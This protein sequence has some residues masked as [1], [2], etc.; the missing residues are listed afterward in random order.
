MSK[1]A[2]FFPGQGAQHV[3]MGRKLAAQATRIC[4]LRRL[5]HGAEPVDDADESFRL[6]IHFLQD[7]HIDAYSIR[8][9]IPT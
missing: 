4:P 7:S 6:P 2:L 5:I 1:I 9:L 8:S 3:G